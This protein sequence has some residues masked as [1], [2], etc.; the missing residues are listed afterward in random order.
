MKEEHVS[1]GDVRGIGMF[2]TIEFVR[3]RE[4]KEPFVTRKD[5]MEGRPSIIKEISKAA[6]ERGVYVTGPGW[7]NHLMIAP[8]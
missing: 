6:M 7:G 3:N 4:T 5:F 2:W 8:R 1:I